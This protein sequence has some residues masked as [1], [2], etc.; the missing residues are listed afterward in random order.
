MINGFHSTK[1][2]ALTPTGEIVFANELAA[3][4]FVDESP[5]SVVGKSLL[6]L[7]PQSWAEE[8]IQ[9][10][11]LAI[12]KEHP[13]LV[14]E[15]LVG[16]RFCS[17]V[18]P[19]KVDDQGKSDWM[20]LVTVEQITPTELQRLRDRCTP[21]QLFNVK[22]HDLG[23]LSILSPRELEVLALMGQG[24]RQKQIAERLHRSVSTIDRHRER[25]GEKLNIADRVE[26]VGLAREAALETTDAHRLNAPF[27]SKHTSTE[28]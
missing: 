15:I 16:T 13:I 2:L 21:D 3:A 22:V 18:S 14:T 19:I 17:T 23:R 25:I 8:R 24:L 20:L 26:L 27:E 12:E 28:S 1:V 5:E 4:V 6:D 9:F 10:L 11:K 7:S